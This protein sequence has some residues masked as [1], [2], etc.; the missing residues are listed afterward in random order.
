VDRHGAAGAV[1]ATFV[2]DSRGDA[3]RDL[4]AVECAGLDFLVKAKNRS[5]I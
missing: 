1:L 5:E 2:L 4:L 3:I